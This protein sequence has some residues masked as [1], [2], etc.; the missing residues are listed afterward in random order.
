MDKIENEEQSDDDNEW[1]GNIDIAF[2]KY[3]LINLWSMVG[4]CIIVSC[5]F[6]WCSEYRDK[7]ENDPDSSNDDRSLTRP[8]SRTVL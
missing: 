7:M 3:I 8:R 4:L 6:I 1:L 2:S 5:I